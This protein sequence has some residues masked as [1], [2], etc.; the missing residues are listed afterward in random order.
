MTAKGLS[1][2][3]RRGGGARSATEGAVLILPKALRDRL[4]AEA[5]AA[6]PHEACGLFEGVR[7]GNTVVVTAL[8][9]AANV[10]PSPQ[11]SFALD[12]AFHLA[13]Q[14]T[15]RGCGREIVGCYHS[16]PNGQAEPSRRDRNSG[17]ADGFVWI[18]IATGVIDAVRAFSGPAFAPLTIRE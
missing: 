14:R 12:P 8:H 17:C 18:I 13:L 9:P 4:Q 3:G 7:D 5:R 6:A 1:F 2:P 10:S 16:H 15:L 11:D